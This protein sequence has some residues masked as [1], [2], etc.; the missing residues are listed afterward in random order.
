VRIVGRNLDS[1][2]TYLGHRRVWWIRQIPAGRDFLA[3]DVAVVTGIV[4]RMETT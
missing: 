2:Y 3:S 4:I 1:L